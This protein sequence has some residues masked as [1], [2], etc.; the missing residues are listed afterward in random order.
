ML[1]ENY[2]E[3][4]DTNTVLMGHNHLN[5][6]EA[7]PFALLKLLQEGD[8]IFVTDADNELK[9]FKVFASRKIASDD[10]VEPESI[11]VKF[12]NSLTLMTCKD[13]DSEGTYLFR[14]VVAVRPY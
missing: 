8:M 7:G 9:S 10:A 1:N 11:A 4:V 13:E 12:A 3:Y 14:R 5:T 6:T 2:Q